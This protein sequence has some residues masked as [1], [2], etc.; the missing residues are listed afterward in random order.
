MRITRK[1]KRDSIGIRENIAPESAT[2]CPFYSENV[3][4]RIVEEL[5]SVFAINDKYPVT[6][7]SVKL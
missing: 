2:T 5:G 3:R 1:V 6:Y 7:V 4:P